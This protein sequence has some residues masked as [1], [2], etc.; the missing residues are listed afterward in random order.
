MSSA[1]PVPSQ[2]AN[3][4]KENRHLANYIPDVWG[5]TFLAPPPQLD[6]DGITRSEYKELKEQVRRMLVTN[7]DNP[8][9]KLDLIDA[10]QRLGVAYH[11]DK[12]IEDALQIIHHHHCTHTQIDD[13][14]LYTTAIRFRLLREHGFNVDCETFNKFKDKEGEF[15]KS[16]ISDVKGMLQ[17]YEAAHFQLH[18]E[19]ILEEVLSFTNFHL[20]LA[21]T[22]VDYPLFTQIVDALNRPLRKSLPR[23]VARRFI[24]IYQGYDTHNQNLLKFA[25]LDFKIVQHLHRKEINELTRWWRGLDVP[26]NFPFTRDRFMECYF[27]ILGVYFEPHYTVARNFTTK[28]IALISILDDIYDAY[29]TY[30]ELEIF[31]KAI[32]RWDINCIDQLPDC[33]KVWYREVL[34]VYKDMGDLMSKEGKTYR[35]EFA[36]DAMKRQS[37]VYCVEAKW[38]HEKYIPTM[39]EYMSIALMSSAYPNLTIAS[40]VCME[41]NI[42]KDTFIWAFNVPKMLKASSTICRLMD[43]VV[44][45]R[46]EQERGHVSSAVECY[47]KQYGTSMQA[48]YD[49]FFKQIKDAWKDINEGFLKPTAAPTSALNRILNLTKVIDLFYMGESAYDTAGDSAKTNIIAVFDSI[50]I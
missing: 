42:T 29:G 33:M 11:F 2:D 39:E 18:G 1:N 16:L 17:L 28:V 43:D 30:E 19:N 37:Q 6:M 4:S 8:S 13:D 40:L 34:N 15:K 47:M 14:D 38:F 48:T 23:L 21:E 27:W 32:H 24:S 3:L 9:Q 50:P 25:K 44:T 46:F 20:K 12:E 7:M 36:I 5:D 41:D 10:V 22:K 31:T 49:E 45:H 35:I 26:I